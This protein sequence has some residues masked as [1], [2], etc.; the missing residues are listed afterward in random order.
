MN[1]KSSNSR[2]SSLLDHNSNKEDDSN[3]RL[4]GAVVVADLRGVAVAVSNRMLAVIGAMS[5]SGLVAE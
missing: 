4:A 1:G 3:N 5:L 2:G